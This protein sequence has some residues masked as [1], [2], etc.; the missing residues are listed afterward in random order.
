M[1]EKDWR[2]RGGES[3]DVPLSRANRERLNSLA[4]IWEV[5]SVLCLWCL[6]L[7]L[8]MIYVP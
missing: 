6:F 7:F 5:T 3:C 2:R 1:G 8:D 4:R